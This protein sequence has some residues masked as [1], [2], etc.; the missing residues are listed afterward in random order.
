MTITRCRQWALG[1][2]FM[3]SGI[4]LM[5]L[6]LG[7]SVETLAPPARAGL[8]VGG[9]LLGWF[10]VYRVA[11]AGVAIARD[12]VHVRNP[13][14]S[15]FVRWAEIEGFDLGRYAIFSGIGTVRLRDGSR[16]PLFGVQA[17]ESMFNPGDRQAHEIVRRLN[18]ALAANA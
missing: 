4:G 12:G 6:N 5:V 14:A 15:R 16:L 17:V 13:L 18:A 8:I 10:L 11:L 3:G 9:G 2:G 7:L 1:L